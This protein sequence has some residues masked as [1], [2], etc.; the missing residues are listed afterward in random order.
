[1]RR[2]SRHDREIR[3]DGVAIPGIEHVVHALLAVSIRL[4]VINFGRKIAEGLPREV[5]DNGLWHQNLYRHRGLS[6]AAVENAGSRP[7]TAT[8]RPRFGMTRC[9]EGETIAIIGANQ[10][11][12]I[13]P[14]SNP[15]R[16]H[17]WR[18][19]SVITKGR[20]IG[21]GRRR[22]S[23]RSE[24]HWSPRATVFT[25]APLR[26]T[27]DWRYGRTAPGPWTPSIGLRAVSDPE[28]PAIVAAPDPS[29]ASSRWPPSAA[30]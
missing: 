15:R 17:S 5:I 21:R 11:R 16:S 26:R 14:S 7:S 4:V 3:K 28:R 25:S 18:D 27:A 1:V 6:D 10:R 2:L 13:R 29:A 12:Q 30:P 8:S 20:P 22:I 19:H 24:L 23:S 9:G